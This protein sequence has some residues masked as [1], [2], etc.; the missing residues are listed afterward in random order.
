MVHFDLLMPLGGVPGALWSAVDVLR[1]L[2]ALARLRAPRA[3]TPA[4]SWRVIDAR[5]RTHRF[6]ALT[7]TSDE[8]RRHGRRPAQAQRVL[9]LP[10]L[11]MRSIPALARLVQRNAEAVALARRCF[12]EGALLGACGTGMWLLAETGRLTQAPVPWLYQSGFAA[13][14]PQVEIQASAPILATHRIVCA[15]MP[16]LQHALVLQLMSYAGQADLAHAGSEKLLLN[17]ER[18]DL[19]AAM[20]VEQVMG[21]SRDVPLFRAQSW[22]QAN[23]SRSF[24]LAEAAAVAAISE[25]TLGR[26]FLQH[27][28]Q[29]PLQYVQALRVQRAQMWLESTWRSVEEIAHDCGYADTSAFCRMFARATGTSPQRHRER[30]TFRGP[31]A[32]WRSQEV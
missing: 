24:R 27:L 30:Y 31:R 15:A 5:G 28:G 3:K 21:R 2:N 8:E 9:L 19:S 1:E 22:M 16:S 17:A 20:T 14:F 32:L 10:P 6:H 29:T 18:Q 13:H 4:A 26:L 12:D 23:A 7:C 11:E 25:R